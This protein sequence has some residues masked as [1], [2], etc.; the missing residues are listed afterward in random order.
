MRFILRTL[1]M[2]VHALRRNIMRSALTTLG[3][4]IGVAVV[5]AVTEIGQGTATAVASTIKSMGADNLLVQPGSA[6]SG[7]VS[8]G[9]NSVMTLTPQD[10][11]AIARECPAVLGVAPIVRARAQVVYGNKNWVP[12]Y[13]YGTSPDFLEVREWTDLDEGEAFSKKDV[14]QRAKVCVLGQ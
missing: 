7:G 10:A 8:F 13:I 6:S 2:A 12:V 1:E 5:V 14:T 3:I 4:V 11:D 9:N